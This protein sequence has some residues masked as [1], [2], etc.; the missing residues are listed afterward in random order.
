MATAVLLRRFCFS[1]VFA[2]APIGARAGDDL[3]SA[4]GFSTTDSQCI[5]LQMEGKPVWRV[6][7]GTNQEWPGIT[8][9][10]PL[11]HWDLSNH[12]AVDLDVK[13]IDTNSVTV[14]CRVDN[15]GADGKDHCANGQVT[16]PPGQSRRLHVLLKRAGDDKMDGKLFGMNGYPVTLGGP[17]TIDPSNITQLLIFV[18]KP[19]QAHKFEVSDF[20]STGVDTPPTAWTTDAVPFFPFID[21]FGQYRHKDWPGKTESLADLAARRDAEAAE[22]ARRP[23][24]EDWDKFGGSASGPQLDAT[25]FFRTE[26]YRGKWW[27]VDPDG[28]LFFSHGIDC[29]GA[30]E[31]TPISGRT[32]WFEGFPSQPEFRQFDS[33]SRVLLGHYAGQSPECFSFDSANLLRKYGSQW[34]S[35]NREI[36]QRRLRSW[37]VNTIGNWSDASLAAMRVTPYTDS[38]GSGGSEMIQGSE[39]YWG[40]FPDVFDPSFTN[41]LR[42]AAQ[43]KRGRSA[44]DPWCIGYFSDNEMSWG[45]EL[46]IALATLKSGSNQAAKKV[47]VQDLQAKYGDIAQL[48]AAWGVNHASWDALLASRTTPDE[49]HAR[50]DLEAFYTRAAEQYFRCA[51]QAVKSVAPNQLYLGCRFAWVNARAAAAAA[52][53]CDVV[54]YNIYKPTVAD[55][56]FN[57]GAD[58]PLIIG[59]FHFGA[60]DRG[61]FHPGLV[62]TENQEA[63][64]EAYKEYVLGALRHPQFVGCHWFQYGDEPVTGRSWDGENYQIGFVDV[65]DT[66]YRELVDAARAVGYHLYDQVKN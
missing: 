14:S 31:S 2:L 3:I 66:P 7:T 53:Y 4:G 62:P 58:V 9:P 57:G 32:N 47:F 54:S 65:A 20:R 8:L 59:E 29:V 39:G 21:T 12:A 30:T 55:F 41:A 64:A 11:G 28:H 56:Q 26:K 63:R 25:G 27:L 40:K 46:S 49:T 42:R 24:P 61:L 13:N 37:G 16:V 17:G 60:L 10:A 50:S 15:P 5:V 43:P 45:D 36:I 48:N 51:R 19:S 34:H 33:R 35:I 44:N 38:I 52:K 23:G 18:V 6:S 22:L 1:V